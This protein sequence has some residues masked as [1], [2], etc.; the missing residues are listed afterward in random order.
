[1]FKYN[2]T[3]V[4]TGYLKQLLSSVNIPT[5]RIYTRE[6]AKYLEYN[7]KEDPRI[8][9]SFDTISKDRVANRIAYLK[10]NELYN[11]FWE[12]DSEK[13]NFGHDEACWQRV[14]TVFYDSGKAIPGLTRVLNSPGGFYD[15][16]THEYLGDYLR[17]LRDYYNV[18]LMS[19]YNCFTNEI[20]NNITYSYTQKR[21]ANSDDK[22]DIVFNSN[23]S[24]YRIY[25]IP[26]KLF[27]N[28]TIAIDSSHGVEL[29]CG[30]YNN[31]LD[32]SGKN[33]DLI[34]KTY[35]KIN[36]TIFNQP[37]IYDKLS[38]DYWSF[39]SSM[40]KDTLTD[41][42]KITR[43]DMANRE[44]DLKL[45]IKVPTSCKSSITVLEGDFRHYNDFVYAPKV[46]ADSTAPEIWQYKQNHSIV[47]FGNKNDIVKIDTNDSE[48]YPI[49]KLQLLEFNTGESYPFADRLVEYLS[50][51][52]ITSLDS[53][54]DN[55]R[56]AQRVMKQNNHYFRIEGLWEDK[57]QKIIYD[58]IVNSGPVE[59]PAKDAPLIDKRQGYHY[60]LGHSNK[61][62]LYD[63]LGYVD[64][65]AEKWYASWKNVNGKAATRNSIQSIDIY[66]GLY[67]I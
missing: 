67:D 20:C 32:M 29:F 8:L 48:F 13:E 58:Y 64:R 37:F 47:N 36:S 40:S 42:N 46:S 56:R 3:H 51:S 34:E 35:I 54:H 60:R 15:K 21:S 53:I 23:D 65:D 16:H 33:A 10:D 55:I 66:D 52:T 7:K 62:T 43:W 39:D 45:F 5:C 59:A 31:R 17:F 25:V 22:I 50:G 6:F 19:L 27:A 12:Y 11:Y 30:L 1:M 57:M 2:N 63:V 44:Q 49:S 41:I 24:K 61:S 9:E 26:V 18:N 38:I 28:Y 4:F 14:S